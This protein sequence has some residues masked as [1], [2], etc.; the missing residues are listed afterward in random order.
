MFDNLNET[1]KIDLATKRLRL[2]MQLQARRHIQSGIQFHWLNYFNTIKQL[3]MQY[4]IES[5]CHVTAAEQ[6]F[7]IEAIKALNHPELNAD[8]ITTSGE[9]ILDKVLKDHPSTS[10]FKY[11]MDLPLLATW[12]T[13]VGDMLV[14]AQ[15]L[16]QFDD[17]P[18]YF[19]SDDCSPILQLQWNELTGHADEIFDDSCISLIFTDKDY[20]WIIF[21]SIEN[22]WRCSKIIKN[23]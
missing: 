13:N 16:L 1:Q 3:G 11:V 23:I 14:K 21:R 15:E 17:G 6:P 19:L 7:Y 2:Q 18:V 5:L 20:S 9:D 12:N 22:E 10:A 8:M 4:S